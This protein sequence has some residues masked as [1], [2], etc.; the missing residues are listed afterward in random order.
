MNSKN[1]FRQHTPDND[2]EPGAPGTGQDVCPECVGTGKQVD[3]AS[4]Q[5]TGKKCERC[6]GTGVVVQAIG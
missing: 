1:P 6:G 4:G 5:P 3:K 2:P